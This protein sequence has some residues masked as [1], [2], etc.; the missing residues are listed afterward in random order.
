MF[1]KLIL[2]LVVMPYKVQKVPIKINV[3][4]AVEAEVEASSALLEIVQ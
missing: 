3:L 1:A 2:L 4:H